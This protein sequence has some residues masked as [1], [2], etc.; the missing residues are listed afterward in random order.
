MTDILTPTTP[1]DLA[2]MLREATNSNQIVVPCGAGTR[3]HIGYP[4]PADVIQLST[5]RLSRVLDHV[6]PDMTVTVEAG[7]TLGALQEVLAQSNQWL[8][9]DPPSAMTATIG[10][11]LATAASGPLRLGYGTPRDWVLGMRVALGDGRLVKSGGK[12]VKNVAGYDTHKLHIGALGT[13]GVIAEV[14][15]KVFPLPDQMRTLLAGC[16][17]ESGALAL[18][19]KLRARPLAPVSM[20]VLQAGAEP[21]NPFAAPSGQYIV[22]A[23]FAGVPAAV[24]RQIAAAMDSAG[25]STLVIEDEQAR[26]LWQRIANRSMPADDSLIIRAAARPSE[27]GRVLGALHGSVLPGAAGPEVWGYSGVGIAYG[28]WTL[29]PDVDTSIVTAMLN[30]LR[31]ALAPVDGYAVVEAAPPAMHAELDLWGPAPATLPMMR[32]VRE[33]WDG[34]AILNR[35]R[36]LRGL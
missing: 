1:A 28:R 32:A 34:A 27:L 25:A 10:G 4:P 13:L 23:R 20:I 17:D 31:A 19:E 6:A 2:A 12:V 8:P 18:A 30:R 33:Q 21:L 11:L 26:D 35:G 5:I 29:A 7:M 22:A 36:Y 16:H 9:W 15:F 14:S 24:E 3:M